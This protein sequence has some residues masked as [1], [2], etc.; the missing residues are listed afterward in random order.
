MRNIAH[1]RAESQLTSA[2]L[3][4]ARVPP[5]SPFRERG[6]CSSHASQ[7]GDDFAQGGSAPL[8]G[9]G[10]FSEGGINALRRV[11]NFAQ[12]GVV[13]TESGSD[14]SQR[15]DDLS[16]GGVVFLK[17]GPT[18]SAPS[19]GREP[20]AA[21]SD[22]KAALDAFGVTDE[23]PQLHAPAARSS[24]SATP[25]SHTRNCPATKRALA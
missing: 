24:H 18:L 5:S 12:D 19:S 15:A 14:A 17:L 13:F 10:V 22:R 11:D 7:R 4:Q 21:G 8:Q 3:V 16:Q 25:K 9:G 6:C 2:R 1:V 20:T 23:S